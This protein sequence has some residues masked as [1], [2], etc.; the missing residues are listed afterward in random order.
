[1]ATII[2]QRLKTFTFRNQSMMKRV[3]HRYN[4]LH[5]ISRDYRLLWRKIQFLCGNNNS[6]L[7]SAAA[8]INPLFKGERKGLRNKHCVWYC[9][10]T[11]LD[12]TGVRFIE[13]VFIQFLLIAYSIQIK[14]KCWEWKRDNISSENSYFSNS[15][16]Y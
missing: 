12:V 3:F 9:W 7:S 13:Y 10:W 6:T 2:N 11:Y 16:V 4:I 5:N 1:M 8:G 14:L 15:I